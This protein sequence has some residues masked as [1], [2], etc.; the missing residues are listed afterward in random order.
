MRGN[1]RLDSGIGLL[2][3]ASAALVGAGLLALALSVTGSFLPYEFR[4]VGLTR[5]DL[6][7]IADCRVNGFMA[8]DRAAF[9]GAL[10]GIGVQYLYLVLGPLRRGLAWA[11]WLLAVSASVGVASFLAFFG[12]GYVDPWHGAG[13]LVLA[14]LL[15]V[16]LFLTRPPRAPYRPVR[17]PYR[18]WR[19]PSSR[20]PDLSTRAGLG[21]AILLASSAGVVLA[22]L[23]I[24]RI[25]VTR[26]FVSQDLAFMGVGA[27][28]LHALDPGL[29]PL[30]AHDR[31]SF[32]AAVVVTGLTTLGHVWFGRLT[33][34]MWTMLLVA[35]CS[36]LA[37]AV[38]THFAVGYVD[39]WHLAPPVVAAL[40]L[41]A[42]LALTFPGGGPPAQATRRA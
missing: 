23:E 5:A 14:A 31:I 42:G 1:R 37:A 25:G 40:A 30:I 24:F 34:T 17:D 21:R 6:C 2:V 10:V 8:H 36:A 32:G 38:G 26:V 12:S 29:I 16:G 11:W 9:G 22:G 13:T 4:G 15:G 28:H 35:G 3:A 7:G 27:H 33:R 18:R 39:A 41:L 20:L 19:D